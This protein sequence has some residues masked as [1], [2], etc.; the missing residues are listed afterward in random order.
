MIIKAEQKEKMLPDFHVCVQ[1]IG[2]S[3]KKGELDI[4]KYF[5]ILK[6]IIKIDCLRRLQ[7]SVIGIIKIRLD[8]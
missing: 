7:T 3:K 2:I 1:E 6:V 4:Q 5:L 8:K